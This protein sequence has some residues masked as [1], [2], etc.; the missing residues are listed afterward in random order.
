M[1]NSI[2]DQ[3]E[4]FKMGWALTFYCQGDP[5]LVESVVRAMSQEFRDDEMEDVYRG[6]EHGTA[7]WS[8]GAKQQEAECALVGLS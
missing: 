1:N 6:M 8:H 5:L 2:C 7:A 4:R 3:S